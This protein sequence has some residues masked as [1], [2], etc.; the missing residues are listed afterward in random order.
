VS[1]LTFYTN[2]MSRGQIAH[3]MLE[4]LGEPYETI[5]LP[6]GPEGNKSADYLQINPMGKVPCLVHDG[7]VVTE[8]AAICVYLADVFPEA[9]L[10]PKPDERADYYRW[11]FFAAGPVEQAVT[12][13]ALGLEAPPDKAAT[14]GYGTYDH[15][16]NALVGHLEGR[17]YV[18]GDRFNAADVYVGSAVDWGVSFETMPKLP[19]L[20]DYAERL[21]KRQAYARAKAINNAKIAEMKKG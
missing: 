2:P 13:K 1:N 16:I 19:A 15:T 17:P 8:A 7:A 10:G 6:W 5:W 12:S 9:E 18:C 21:Q 11:I 14:V 20:V 3:W 4:E